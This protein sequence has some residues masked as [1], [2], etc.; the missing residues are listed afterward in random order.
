MGE[1]EICGITSDELYYKKIMGID[2][3]PKKDID[4]SSFDYLIIMA[5][6]DMLRAINKEAVAM[7]IDD[8][9]IVPIK[10]MTLPGFAFEKYQAIRKNVPTIISPNCWGGMIYNR[11][12]FKS[13]FINMFETHDDFLK[14]LKNIELYMK[15]EL[16][17][18]E[19]KYVEES[20]FSYPVVKC[21]DVKLHCNHY[22]SFEEANQCWKRRKKRMNLSNS[23]VMLYDGDPDRINQFKKL[24]YKRKICFVPYASRDMDLMPL[25]YTR[26]VP[27]MSF[28]KIVNE[29][30]QGYLYDLFELLL[31]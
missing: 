16:Q 1:V 30:A 2:F 27:E 21:A 9:T 5:E 11:L 26:M 19:M 29:G 23:I 8:S 25:D 6:A 18:V 15:A 20:D 4:S 17:L 12:E 3:I 24:E 22:H 13:P 7:G 28:W 14:I 10:V 31:K